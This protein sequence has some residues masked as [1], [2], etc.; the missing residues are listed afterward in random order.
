MQQNGWTSSTVVNELVQVN[1]QP[2]QPNTQKCL[3][4]M[5]EKVDHPQVKMNKN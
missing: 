1:D 5:V 2:I 3:V 4:E